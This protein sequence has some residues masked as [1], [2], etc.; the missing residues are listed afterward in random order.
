V[1]QRQEGQCFQGERSGL[2]AARPLRNRLC[3]LRLFPSH[4]RADRYP[5][6][7]SWATYV[8]PLR[9]WLLLIIVCWFV[10]TCP[11]HALRTTAKLQISHSSSP[12]AADGQLLGRD[13]SVRV[14]LGPGVPCFLI[15]EVRPVQR[16]PLHGAEAGVADDAAELLFCGAIRHAGGTHHIFFQHH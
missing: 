10:I 9:G 7:T 16:V 5:G 3:R 8:S 2:R 1:V 15:Q 14:R 11:Q 13:V 4:N 12:S 6:L